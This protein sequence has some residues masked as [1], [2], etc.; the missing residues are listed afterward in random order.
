MGIDRQGVEFPGVVGGVDHLDDPR[1]GTVESGVTEFRVSSNLLVEGPV[2]DMRPVEG[3]QDHRAGRAS[4]PGKVVVD[5]LHA[6]AGPVVVGVPQFRGEHVVREEGDMWIEPAVER[7]RAL[8][9]VEIPKV[10][11]DDVMV[12][13]P[14]G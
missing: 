14:P 9:H 5:D 10:V 13:R 3:I 8:D 6:P 4:E 11:V 7:D 1:S 2:D 12:P